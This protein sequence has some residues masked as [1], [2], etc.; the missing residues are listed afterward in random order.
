MVWDLRTTVL[1]Q[2][3]F[4]LRGLEARQNRFSSDPTPEPQ[5]AVSREE[6]W[7]GFKVDKHYLKNGNLSSKL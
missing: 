5:N 2:G 4:G 1:I 6:C 7:L 3:C